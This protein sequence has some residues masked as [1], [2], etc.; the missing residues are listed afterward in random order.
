MSSTEAFRIKCECKLTRAVD[1]A[2][3]FRSLSTEA[4]FL[5]GLQMPMTDQRFYRASGKR[6]IE[7]AVVVM[8]APVWVPVLALASLVIRISLGRPVVYRQQR[9]GLHGKVFEILKLRTMKDQRDSAG[10][11]LPDEARLTRAGRI[12]RRLSLDELPELLNVLS[13]DMSLVG[14][15]PLLVQY[16]DRYTPLQARRHEIRP[17]ITGWA[18]VNGR[19][20]LTWEEKFEFDVWY[21]DHMSFWLDLRIL[22][23]TI[24]KAPSGRGVTAE[25]HATMPEFMGTSDE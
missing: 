18:Q 8:A 24:W 14:P 12:L 1:T 25:G 23:L 10:E 15:R 7:L 2:Q 6:L 20:A 3:L 11:L 5:Q 16:L 22:W 4:L 9:P 19:N 21:V 13:G 17:G